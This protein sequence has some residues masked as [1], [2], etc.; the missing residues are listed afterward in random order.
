MEQRI[1]LFWQKGENRLKKR[2]FNNVIEQKNGYMTVEAVFVM[3][4]VIAVI[5]FIIYS[6]F[7]LC[8]RCVIAGASY[9]GSVWG[10]NKKTVQGKVSAGEMSEEAK[11]HAATIFFGNVSFNDSTSL[12]KTRVSVNTSRKLFSAPLLDQILT[13][14]NWNLSVEAKCYCPDKERIIRITKFI[15]Q[16]KDKGIKNG[17]KY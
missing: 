7:F 10:A 16:S 12:E 14:L 13:D 5:V 17:N 15:I 6:G 3:I 11:K 2:K 9:E 4:I 8:D 1:S